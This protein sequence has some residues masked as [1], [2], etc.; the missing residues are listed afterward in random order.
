MHIP[1]RLAALAACLL[2]LLCCEQQSADKPEAQ[3]QPSSTAVK[4]VPLT[5]KNQKQ[6]Q[7]SS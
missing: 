5:Q 2:V 6:L 3:A 4:A 1:A 7:I